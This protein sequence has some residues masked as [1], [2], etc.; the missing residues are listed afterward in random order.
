[1]RFDVHNSLPFTLFFFLGFCLFA[2]LQ[3]S[4]WTLWVPPAHCARFVNVA[5]QF[6][7]DDEKTH[8]CIFVFP[9]PLPAFRCFY[10]TLATKRAQRVPSPPPVSIFMIQRLFVSRFLPHHSYSSSFRCRFPGHFGRLLHRAAYTFSLS[11]PLRHLTICSV[12][13]SCSQLISPGLDE[14]KLRSSF[15]SR[16]SGRPLHS[17]CET[18]LGSSQKMKGGTEFADKRNPKLVARHEGLCFLKNSD[19]MQVSRGNR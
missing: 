2:H 6:H 12:F 10:A 19:V 18:E 3:C 16:D 4:F 15:P 11:A 5:L 13:S 1:M 9:L 14:R 8:N 7:T 17:C